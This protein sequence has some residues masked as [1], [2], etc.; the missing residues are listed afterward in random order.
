MTRKLRKATTDVIPTPA[1]RRV[2][3][4]DRPSFW[5]KLAWIMPPHAANWPKPSTA[6]MK[7]GTNKELILAKLAKQPELA[8]A[9][10]KPLG[11]G[12]LLSCWP[13]NLYGR[14][15]THVLTATAMPTADKNAQQM[16]L[17]HTAEEIKESHIAGVRQV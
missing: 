4:R 7:K 17:E 8:Q 12:P 10:E 15:T 6:K 5:K 11:Y 3:R 2:A 9:K 1:P 16:A 13:P 14:V